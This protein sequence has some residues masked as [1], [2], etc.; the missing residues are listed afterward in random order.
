M[1]LKQKFISTVTLAFAIVAFT[2]FV[3][4]QDTTTTNQQDSI[5]KQ[6]KRERKGRGEGR[7]DVES[8]GG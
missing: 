5:N 4:A 3:S 1:S 7:R 2:T 8:R 6:E